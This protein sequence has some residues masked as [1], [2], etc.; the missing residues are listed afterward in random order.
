[1]PNP[2][3]RVV[4]QG[5]ELA[6]LRKFYEQAFGWTTYD[7]VPDYVGVE[8]LPH[9]HDQQGNYI[10][11]PVLLQTRGGSLTWRF[12]GEAHRPRW[13]TPGLEAGLSSGAPAVRVCIDVPDI[14]AAIAAVERA[15]AAIVSPPRMIP[16]STTVALIADPAGN[17]IE[18]QQ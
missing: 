5:P 11:P 2:I 17:T 3:V 18:L 7:I 4:L 13:L 1:M 12:E 8:P 15:G 14:D 10:T 9:E 6:V 16:A